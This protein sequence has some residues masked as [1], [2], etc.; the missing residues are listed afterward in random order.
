VKTKV[1]RKYINTIVN[2]KQY[3]FLKGKY[4]YGRKS[5]NRRAEQVLPRGLVPVGGGGCEERAWEGE[6]TVYTSM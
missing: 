3:L 4:M 1:T 6:Y 2:K 5:E